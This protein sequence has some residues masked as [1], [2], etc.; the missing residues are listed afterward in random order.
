MALAAGAGLASLAVCSVAFVAICVLVFS[1]ALSIDPFFGMLGSP[2]L[3]P[4]LS[5]LGIGIALL[6]AAASLSLPALALGASGAH[7]TKTAL[8]SALGFCVSA[9]FVF[10]FL[11]AP[12]GCLSR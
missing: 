5:L 6:L 3:N 11:R 1:I 8:L 4:T 7:L 9:F 2:A 12:L 10:V